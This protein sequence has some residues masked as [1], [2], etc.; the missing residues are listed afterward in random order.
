MKLVVSSLLV[1][2]ASS[3][4]AAAAPAQADPNPAK[5]ESVS[6]DRLD[7][8]RRFVD[9]TVSP[10]EYM[11][12]M[13]VGFM[14]STTSQLADLEDDSDFAAAEEKMGKVFAKIDPLMRAQLPKLLEA[15]AQAY[16]REYSADELRQ[17]AVPVMHE[18]Q[19]EM[20]AE[21]AA[22]RI[23]MGDTKAKCPLSAAAETQSG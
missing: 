14:A 16:A 21:K 13:R 1:A 9:L 7:L 23:A 15:Y 17:L 6:P 20:C 22:Q 4:I 19:K 12:M 5:V 10:D 8:A 11:E 3:A 2:F 18:L